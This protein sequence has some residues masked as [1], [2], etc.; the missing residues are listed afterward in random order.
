MTRLDVKGFTLIEVLV[1]FLLLTIGLLGVANMQLSGKKYNFEA[2]QR[3]QAAFY[4]NDIIERMR[5]NRDQLVSYNKPENADYVGIAKSDCGGQTTRA[6]MD[7]CE[8][9]SVVAA[10]AL[11]DTLFLKPAF[12]ITAQTN[13]K[14]LIAF[15]W[16]GMRKIGAPPDTVTNC[17]D[18]AITDKTYGRYLAYNLYVEP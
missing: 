1:T 15:T 4:L 5:A 6:A 11:G 16:L 13:G 12:C 17:F 9:K 18:A 3:S 7:L 2:W 14:V 8:V 10:G